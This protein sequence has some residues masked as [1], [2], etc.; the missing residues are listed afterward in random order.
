MAKKRV[1][2]TGGN[3]GVGLETTK[4]FLAAGYEVVVIGRDFTDFSLGS[5]P[6]VT[7]HQFDLRQ[8]EGI[9]GLARKVGDIDVLVNNAGIMNTCRYDDYPEQQRLDLMKVNIEAPVALI[10][11]FSQGMIAKKSGRII[12]V[13]SIASEIG[14]PDIWYGISKAGLTNATKS[15]GR[16]LGVF[17]IRVN[18]VAPGPI[19]TE[20]LRTAIPS[21]RVEMLRSQTTLKRIADPAEVA[22]VIFWLATGAPEYLN[23]ICL[24]LN[25]TAHLR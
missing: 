15:F 16:Q 11:E 12:N 14:H 4:K 6:A 3:K 18:A 5:D 17:G 22:E 20:M 19:D 25:D 7:V 23:G 8:I 9:P 10:R 13:S 24:D 2:V 21:D 1:L